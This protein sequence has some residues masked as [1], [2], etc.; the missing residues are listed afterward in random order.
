MES[1]IIAL[2]VIYGTAM[3]VTDMFNADIKSLIVMSYLT[4]I[5]FHNSLLQQELR[6]FRKELINEL[7]KDQEQRA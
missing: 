2:L 4:Y 6:D 7:D 5:V 1:T 3:I